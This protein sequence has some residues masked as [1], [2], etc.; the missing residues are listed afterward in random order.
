MRSLSEGILPQG[1]AVR[2]AGAKATKPWRRGGLEVLRSAGADRVPRGAEHGSAAG[3]GAGESPL[4][5]LQL[6]R[7]EAAERFTMDRQLRQLERFFH[8]LTPWRGAG[9]RD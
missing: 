9:G 7:A 3:V 5:R 6:V 8:S 2:D 1:R 4:H